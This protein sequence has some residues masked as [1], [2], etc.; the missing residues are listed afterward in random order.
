MVRVGTHL[1]D[2]DAKLLAIDHSRHDLPR[3]VDPG[4]S[5]E[6]TIEVPLPPEGDFV[7]GVDLVAEGVIWFEHVGSATLMVSARRN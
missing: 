7:V 2:R 4:E 6:M 3:N 5:I 1:Y